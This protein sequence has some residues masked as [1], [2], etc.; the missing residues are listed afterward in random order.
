ML[1]TVLSSLLFAC[2][3]PEAGPPPSAVVAPAAPTA[4]AAPVAAAAPVPAAPV[5]ASIGVSLADAPADAHD[6]LRAG[7]SLTSDGD[8]LRI[9]ADAAFRL[10][11]ALAPLLLGAKPEAYDAGEPRVK[12]NAFHHL[13]RTRPAWMPRADRSLGYYADAEVDPAHA[14]LAVLVARADRGPESVEL[15]WGFLAPHLDT[16]LPKSAWDEAGLGQTVRDLIAAHDFMMGGDG[17][18]ELEA[19]Y[20][21]CRA[22]ESDTALGN[23]VYGRSE[24]FHAIFAAYD[25]PEIAAPS[26]WFV[27]FWARRQHEGN[28]EVVRR[29]LQELLAKYEPG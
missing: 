19:L 4:P 15:L 12:V 10:A 21:K 28:R 6:A 9:D 17:E 3:A 5:V 16:L 29:M 26:A 1:G 18:A 24:A 13:Y 27:S 14:A 25:R 23:D 22:L 11:Q 20:A 2:G 7:W 8:S